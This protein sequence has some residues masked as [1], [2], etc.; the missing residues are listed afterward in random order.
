MGG[1]VRG[2]LPAVFTVEWLAAIFAA[3]VGAGAVASTGQ[4]AGGVDVAGTFGV[5]ELSGVDGGWVVGGILLSAVR[6]L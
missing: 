5:E 2:F 4:V 6:T 3:A 1:W